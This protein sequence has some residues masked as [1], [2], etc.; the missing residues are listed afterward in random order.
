LTGSLF[1]SRKT[2][3]GW[4][5]PRPLPAPV[6]SGFNETHASFAP[7]GNTIYFSS[8][9]PGGHGGKDIYYSNRLP[10]G[11]WGK[12]INPGKNINTEW[13]E[14]GPFIHPDNKTLYFS[15]SGHN[16]MGGYDIFKS[17]KA[18]DGWTKAEN[19]GYPV[20]SGDDDVFYVPTPNG[21][22]VYF[23][24]RKE[25]T[26]GQSDLFLFH[27]PKNSQRYLAVVSSHVFNSENQP[28]GNAIIF[29]TNK[30]TKE[31]T[32]TYR[33]NPATGKFVAI[34]P[35]CEKYELTIECKGQKP[36]SQTFELGL[37]DDYKSKERAIYL[38]PVTLEPEKEQGTG[39]K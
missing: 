8:E 33:V 28:A 22:R 26:L 9:R 11:T 27:F 6:N 37:K 24:S 23:S 34:I 25:G 13:D 1:I 15:S 10:D 2:F 35:A 39:Q 4:S 7:D 14:E 5:E 31:M 21:Q 3:D 32:G 38:P 19:I 29:V 20:N 36:H 12:P 17:T 16:S 18:D 30:T